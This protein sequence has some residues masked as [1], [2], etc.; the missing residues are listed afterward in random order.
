MIF[1]KV[2]EIIADTM[3]IP[4]DEIHLDSDL[5]DDLGADSIDA[6]ELSISIEE[7][8][9]LD[10]DDDTITRFKTVEDIVD[11]LENMKGE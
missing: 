5:V 10:I 9:D 4:E 8:F 2:K 7:E 1:E 11:Y 6:V 3:G